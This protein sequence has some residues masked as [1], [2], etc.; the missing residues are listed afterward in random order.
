MSAILTLSQIASAITGIAAAIILL[1][2]P[3]REKVVGVKDV[4]D[5]Q[6]C[7]LRDTMLRTY[8]KH[9]EERQLR[10]YEYENFLYCFDAYKAL[11]G[12]SFIDKIMDELKEWEVVS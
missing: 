3:L 8:Y 12:N 9:R 10:Q 11:G 5:G 6:K 2:K 7:L 1:V 4:R